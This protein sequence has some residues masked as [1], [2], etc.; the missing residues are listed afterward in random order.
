MSGVRTGAWSAGASI[1]ALAV[2]GAIG[3]ALQEPWLFPSLGPTLMVMLE[4]PRL[5]P[6]HPRSV[7]VGH[8]VGIAAGWLA[9]VVMGLQHHPSAVQEGLYTKR[10]VAVCLAMGITAL[11]LQAIRCP[12]PPAGATTMIVSL[13]ILH[14]GPQLR[15][16]ALSVLL[17]TAVG[18]VLQQLMLTVQEEGS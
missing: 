1:V 17:V 2:A 3:I 15:A 4:T 9:L 11:V 7:L 14:T 8:A 12:H 18:L 6:A 13:G 5:P 16:M 10:V